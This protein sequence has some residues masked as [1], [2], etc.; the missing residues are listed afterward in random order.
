MARDRRARQGQG[1]SSDTV[2]FFVSDGLC[3]H[4]GD[5]CLRGS[6]APSVEVEAPFCTPVVLSCGSSQRGEGYKY[7]VVVCTARCA[8]C[9]ILSFLQQVGCPHPPKPVCTWDGSMCGGGRWKGEEL[10]SILLGGTFNSPQMLGPDTGAVI[11]CVHQPCTINHS[12]SIAIGS[13]NTVCQ[14]SA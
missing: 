10:L 1:R 8:F 13:P 9:H 4:T 6:T 2:Y 11:H 3:T 12:P 14:M 5:T 7:M